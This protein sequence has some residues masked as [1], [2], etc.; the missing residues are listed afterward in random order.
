MAKPLPPSTHFALNIS[1]SD[2]GGLRSY[3]GLLIYVYDV[4]NFQPLFQKTWYSFDVLEGTYVMA[5]IGRVS[6]RDG[7]SGL[8]GEVTY[9]IRDSGE[10]VPFAIDGKTGVLYAEGEL[11]REK[12]DKYRLTIVARDGGT[13]AME[14]IVEIEVTVEDKNDNSPQFYAYMNLGPQGVPIYRTSLPVSAPVGTHVTQVFANDSDYAGNGNGLVLFHLTNHLALF[15]IDS[16]NGSI[17]T[18]ARLGGD[19]GRTAVSEYNLTVQASDLG[20]PSMSGSAWV[21]IRL[22]APPLTPPQGR[23]FEK[24]VYIIQVPHAVQAPA[25]I[26]TFNRTV[27]FRNQAL[28]FELLGPA[29]VLS[30]FRL[31]PKS[32]DLFV[33]RGLDEGRVYEFLVRATTPSTSQSFDTRQGKGV[34]DT[35]LGKNIATYLSHKPLILC[36]LV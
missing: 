24:E 6:A 23:V 17:S 8:N 25:Q 22:L 2:R 34:T 33:M 31:H 29:A 15:R 16:Q 30:H 1:A 21:L 35:Y 14:G 10:S 3:T 7:D 9:S 28:Y 18:V 26:A 13:P 36:S 20:K 19:G 27:G 4:N 32:A 11:D 5:E 12:R